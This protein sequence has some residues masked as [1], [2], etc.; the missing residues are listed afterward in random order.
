MQG[1]KLQETQWRVARRAHGHEQTALPSSVVQPY[2]QPPWSF[3]HWLMGRQMPVD[4][5]P[6]SCTGRAPVRAHKRQC[7]D[8]PCPC[9]LLSRSAFDDQMQCH[10]LGSA[11][12]RW[13]SEQVS[14]QLEAV[15]AAA[16]IASR[17]VLAGVL[18][19]RSALCALVNVLAL[20]AVPLPACKQQ[21][22]LH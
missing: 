8:G 13:A 4:V 11:M 15:M 14:H 22:S 2:S 6:P 17:R 20:E 3:L 5:W 18:A 16:F 21:C 19:L 9:T 7:S 10:G 1:L 12:H